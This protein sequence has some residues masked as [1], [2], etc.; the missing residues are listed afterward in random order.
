GNTV[1]G[2]IRKGRSARDKSVKQANAQTIVV[3]S[4]DLDK[5]IASMSIANGAKASGKEVT[6]FFTFWGLNVLR[7]PKACS[8]DKSFLDKIFSMMM[9]KGADKLALSKLNM[10]GLVTLMMKYVMK[11]KNVVSLNELIDQALKNGVKFIAC[12]MSMDIMGIKKEE[13]IDGIEYAGVAKY[14]SESDKANSN[15]FI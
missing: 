14:I 6:L 12:T 4:N 13:L 5:V 1:K 7:K 8:K 2:V 11:K 10:F 15:L 3:F 9:P